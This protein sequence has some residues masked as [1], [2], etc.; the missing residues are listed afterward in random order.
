[1][2][3]ETRRK[4]P[5]SQPRYTDGMTF[6]GQRLGKA[7]HPGRGQ[8]GVGSSGSMGGEKSSKSKKR[9]WFSNV[10]DHK[11]AQVFTTDPPTCLH[12][13]LLKSKNVCHV[14]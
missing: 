2:R 6:R 7:C 11:P 12:R 14:L 10:L 9:E 4:A 5:S 8:G 3:P 13:T 1:M